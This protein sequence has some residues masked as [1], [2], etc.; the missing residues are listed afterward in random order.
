MSDT[1]MSSLK[2]IK[3]TMSSTKFSQLKE[4]NAFDD[5]ID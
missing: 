4:K 2:S 1:K 5:A 3:S